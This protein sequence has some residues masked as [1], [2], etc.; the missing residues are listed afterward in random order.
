MFFANPGHAVQLRFKRVDSVFVLPAHKFI[1]TVNSVQPAV[2]AATDASAHGWFHRMR[3]R[4]ETVDL[5]EEPIVGQVEPGDTRVEAPV[6]AGGA[7][8]HHVTF[9]YRPVSFLH[10]TVHNNP[11]CHARHSVKAS[12]TLY[13]SF[14]GAQE[15][16]YRTSRVL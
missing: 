8:G 5:F 6:G 16:E 9:E 4:K 7:G 13:H 12:M 14:A 1:V 3:L 10:S 2:P 11:V 15:Y